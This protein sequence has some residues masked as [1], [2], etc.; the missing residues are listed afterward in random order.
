MPGCRP[1]WRTISEAD[2]V[3]D[4]S[5]GWRTLCLSA[6]LLSGCNLGPRYR[7]PAMALPAGWTEHAA[8]PDEIAATEAQMRDW[9]ASFHDPLLIL[10]VDQAID[11]NRDLAVAGQ[12]LLAARG[13]RDQIAGMLYPQ[14]DAT[15]AAG[16]QRF[17]TTLE[18]PPLPGINSDNRF[19]QYG[20]TASWELDV[21]G[22]IRHSVEAQQ[23]AYEAG[24]E[25]R[26][27]IL[28]SL[29]SELTTD[30]V[31]L[32]ATQLQLRITDR[33]IQAAGEALQLTNKVYA[34]GLGTTLQVA[35]AQG[36]LETEQA[37]RPPLQTRIAQLAHAIAVLAGQ[38]PGTFEARLDQPAPL[39][40]V[41]PLPV[42][43]PSMV[44]ANRPDI[45][46]AERQYAQSTARVGV[47]IAQLYPSFTLPLS[48]TPQASMIHELFTASSLAWVL[49]LQASAPL[50][51]GGSLSAEVREARAN[52]EV[53]RLTYEQTVL[54]AFQEVEDRLV[55]YQNDQQR[56]AT[57]HRATHDNELALERS[58]RLFGAGLSGFLD[59]LT[60]EQAAYSAQNLEALGE[61]SRLQDAIGLFTALGA[62]WQGVPLTATALPIDEAAQHHMADR[63]P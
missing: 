57:L 34:Q 27:G 23:D 16:I 14:I 43:L 6:L 12:R 53:A 25:Q 52:A 49:L 19:W 54:R 44:V 5:S 40:D 50:Y 47:A 42:T 63:R 8:T 24:I 35:Q 31:T 11:G 32:R 1:G 21:F 38:M 61:L 41:P 3:R 48:F 20:F 9:W 18:Y 51:H 37:T 22:R 58:R 10:L 17:S 7:P 13:L 46:R 28:L 62:G 56:T 26:R 30:Y 15:P 55:A 39:P 29:L 59:V 4:R 36:E 60:S 2:R 33:D 45:R